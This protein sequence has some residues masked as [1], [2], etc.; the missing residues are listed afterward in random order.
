MSG[1]IE[2][3]QQIWIVACENRPGV[4]YKQAKVALDSLLVQADTYKYSK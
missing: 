3:P 4:L 1:V 2:C